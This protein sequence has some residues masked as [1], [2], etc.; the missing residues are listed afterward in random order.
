MSTVTINPPKTPVTEGSHGIASATVPNVCKMPGP[1][2]PFV[3]TPLPNIGRSELTPKGYSVKVRIEGHRVALR[4]ASFG[5]QGDIAAKAS[6]GGIV[7]SNVEGPTTFV[8]LGSLD[9]M[10]EGKNVQLLGDP[11]LNNCGPAGSPPN[12][13]TMLGVIQKS[14]L[15]VMVEGTTECPICHKT[16]EP[17]AE[18]KDSKVDVASLDAAFTAATAAYVDA[19]G[20]RRRPKQS[21]STMLGV[22]LGKCTT[23]WADQSGLTRLELCQASA[24][25][26]MKHPGVTSPSYFE[27]LGDAERRAK[28]EESQAKTIEMMNKLPG[29]ETQAWRKAL[30]KAQ[31]QAEFSSKY[32]ELVPFASYAPGSCA[33]QK[34]IAMARQAG[35]FP[36]ALSERWHA[37]GPTQGKMHFRVENTGKE[38]DLT[39]KPGKSV[40]P[41]GTCN[42][43]LPLLLCPGEEHESTCTHSTSSTPAA[44]TPK[45]APERKALSSERTSPPSPST[46]SPDAPARPAHSPA[47]PSPQPKPS[48]DFSGGGGGFGGGGASGD[49]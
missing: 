21:T 15:F 38:L 6:G 34:V 29:G 13:A 19:N 41:C 7:S 23:K 8:G 16:H 9:V 45:G 4:G 31:E 14:G 47:A 17:L 28:E 48:G 40:P 1:P 12:A 18:T 35:C 26:G 37:K 36:A 32:K 44:D 2:A 33:A 11:M 24:S 39:F 49:W 42:I 10:I 43:L 20:K 3:P 5:S 27:G 30:K 25:G 46:N 22:V